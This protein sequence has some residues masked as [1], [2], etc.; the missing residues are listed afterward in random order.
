[1]Q[2][3][4]IATFQRRPSFDDIDGTVS[5]LKEDL[6]WCENQKV[7]LAIFPECYL[8]GYTTERQTIA[9]RAIAVEGALFKNI[10]A[11]LSPFSTDVI[12]GF[13]EQRNDGF[14]NSAAVIRSGAVKGVYA[15]THP[16]EK[17][18]LPGHETPVFQKSDFLFGIN[19]CFDANFPD[20]AKVLSEKGA[21]LICYPLNNMLAAATAEQWRHRSLENLRSRAMETG[22]W[23][24]SSDVVGVVGEKLSHGCTCI[25]NPQ[26]VIV[27]RV[28]EGNEGAAVFDIG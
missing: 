27:A 17:D 4:R 5:R 12:L 19:I 16:N 26:G 7:E 18:F 9:Q 8:Q 15:K 28:A 13:I 3:I 22:C 2:K 10:L 24:A 25:V 1:M 20:C 6:A 11:R 23:V 21:R 14:Y